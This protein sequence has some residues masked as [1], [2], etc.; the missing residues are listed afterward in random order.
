[1][2]LKILASAASITPVVVRDCK[3]MSAAARPGPGKPY[4]PEQQDI[5][6][7]SLVSELTGRHT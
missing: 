7:S 4:L 5:R 2:E 3:P 6:T 1:M